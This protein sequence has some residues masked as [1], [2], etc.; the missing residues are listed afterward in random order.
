MNSQ[1]ASIAK[2]NRIRILALA[3]VT[4]RALG[5][6]DRHVRGGLRYPLGLQCQ[7]IQLC[8]LAALLILMT[9]PTWLREM[10]GEL[11]DVQERTI[12]S[13]ACP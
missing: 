2:D 13:P 5:V 3:V 4:N 10:R 8:M 11:P 6:F 9:S 1:I 7:L 12:P